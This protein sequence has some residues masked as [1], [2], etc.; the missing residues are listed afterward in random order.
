MLAKF[1]DS[2]LG[3][4]GLESGFVRGRN[5]MLH[6]FSEFKRNFH[7]VH[8]LGT[9]TKEPQTR[10][11]QVFFTAACRKRSPYE[12]GALFGLSPGLTIALPL[13]HPPWIDNVS[14]TSIAFGT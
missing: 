11:Q 14:K 5:V 10:K 6:R 9:D 7:H 13:Y 8:T 3:R 12:N 2:S 4:T 1:E